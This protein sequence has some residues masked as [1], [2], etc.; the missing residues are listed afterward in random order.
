[1]KCGTCELKCPNWAIS[2]GDEI[3]VIDPDKCTECLG[4]YD[5][6]KCVETCPV[7]AVQLN[8]DLGEDYDQLMAKWHRL[9]HGEAPKGFVLRQDKTK[10]VIALVHSGTADPKGEKLLEKMDTLMLSRFPDHDVVWGFQGTYDFPRLRAR[11]QNNYFERQLPLMTAATM[12]A[13][14][15]D[16]G[17]QKVALE[18]LMTSESSHT[19]SALEADTFGMDVKYGKPILSSPESRIA[20][21]KVLEPEYGDGVETAT[22]L[23]GHGSD[24][25]IEFNELYI[26]MDNYVR[27]NYRNVFVA[28]IHGPPEID[29]VIEDVKKSGCSKVRFVNLM[30]TTGHITGDVMSDKPESWKNR[31]GLPADVYTG[32]VELPIYVEYSVNS[33]QPMLDQF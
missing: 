18:L 26:E 28:M 30:I 2:E 24:T 14:L 7:N 16:A 22:V 1:V 25:K 4:F 21:V 33:I 6:P 11:G 29:S 15:A 31:I 20:V 12:L 19:R 27:R 9:H 8:K 3:Y 10:P 17:R 32:I 23:I 5:S 13:R